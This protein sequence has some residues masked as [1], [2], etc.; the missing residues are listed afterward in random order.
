MQERPS[1]MGLHLRYR[2]WIAEMNADINILRIL[3]DYVTELNSKKHVEEV[4]KGI[5]NFKGQFAGFR[6][7]I[8]ELK[9]E[10]HLLKMQ[11][12]ANAKAGEMIDENSYQSENHE[13]LKSRYEGFK[14][15]F[16]QMKSDFSEFEAKWL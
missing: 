16:D 4:E 10:M 1:I 3:D 8:D 5:E 2:L 7:E 12:A 6:K 14:K 15:L 13:V 9:H 11:L